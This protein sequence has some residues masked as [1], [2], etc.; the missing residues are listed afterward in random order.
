MQ[1]EGTVVVEPHPK[2]D[3]LACKLISN[4][5]SVD[6]VI[7]LPRIWWQ[8]ERNGESDVWHG[9]SLAMTRQ[10]FRGYA[11]AGAAIRLRLPPRVASVGVGFDEDLRQYPAQ[12]TEGR[13]CPLADFVD[14]SQIDQRLNSDASLNVQ[15]DDAALKPIRVLADP[16]PE[17][18]SFKSEPGMVISGETATL[19]WVTQN[20]EAGGVVIDPGVGSVE[21]TGS[22]PVA[23]NET[24]IFALRLSA[25][26]LDDVIGV[27]TVKVQ[28]ELDAKPVPQVRG[29]SGR[30][31]RGKGFSRGELRAAGMTEADAARRSITVDKRRRSTHQANQDTIRRLIDD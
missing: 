14:Y 30:L 21:S 8:I 4:A 7:K 3:H 27:V 11:D 26:G 5:G 10:Q 9:T 17:I 19:R 28:P 12:S 1:P 31:Q 24:T 15:C 23:P 18:I 25:S 22:T 16:L 20:A 13:R 29:A 2:G 6:I